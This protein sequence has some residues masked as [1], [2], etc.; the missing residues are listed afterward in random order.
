MLRQLEKNETSQVT[1][2][3]AKQPRDQNK[4]K[5]ESNLI[6]SVEGHSAAKVLKTP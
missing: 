2:K 4:K 6:A 3:T 1:R 5:I